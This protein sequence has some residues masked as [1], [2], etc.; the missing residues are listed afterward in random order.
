MGVCFH[1]YS[2]GCWQVSL[3]LSGYW[4]EASVLHHV[5]FSIGLFIAQL[6]GTGQHRLTME[7]CRSIYAR[8]TIPGAGT[9]RGLPPTLFFLPHPPKNTLCHTIHPSHDYS[10][11]EYSVMITAITV[12]ASLLSA[13]HCGSLCIKATSFLDL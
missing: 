8:V 2:Y 4:L 9:I 1:A 12:F 6:Y 10:S 5:G 13:R 3:V 11:P 7:Q